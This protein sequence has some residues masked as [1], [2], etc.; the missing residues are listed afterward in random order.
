[1]SFKWLDTKRSAAEE[2]VQ[3]RKGTRLR[4]HSG[5]KSAASCG[6]LSSPPQNWIDSWLR[7]LGFDCVG[8]SM[9]TALGFE[10]SP[11]SC[12]EMASEIAAN[13]FCLF[14]DL[15]GAIA[16]AERF[17]VEQPE[18]GDYYVVEVLERD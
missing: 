9:Y 12:N 16:G 7:S 8:K 18:P 17:A 11:L 6:C 5:S 10:C 14:T 3:K 15:D 1:M 13:Q 2:M 4:E